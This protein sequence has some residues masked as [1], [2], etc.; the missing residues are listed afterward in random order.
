MTSDHRKPVESV[1]EVLAAMPHWLAPLFFSLPKKPMESEPFEANV[2]GPDGQC[3]RFT[4][5]TKTFGVRISEE[6][7]DETATARLLMKLETALTSRAVADLAHTC[8]SVFG[9]KSVYRVDEIDAWRARVE[10]DRAKDSIRRFTSH[11]ASFLRGGDLAPPGLITSVIDIANSLCW[12]SLLPLSRVQL[13][14]HEKVSISPSGL[15]RTHEHNRAMIVIIGTLEIVNPEG[16][17]IFDD[18]PLD[19]ESDLPAMDFATSEEL[20]KELIG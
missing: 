13:A 17:Y 12:R 11:E 10:K 3:G 18:G 7:S 14:E 1:E 2:E 16:F 4:Y 8:E 6:D 15:F 20:I 19:R 9:T 5:Q